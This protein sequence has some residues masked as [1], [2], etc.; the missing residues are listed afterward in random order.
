MHRLL[1]NK[2]GGQYVR[3]TSYD[4]ATKLPVADAIQIAENNSN[5]VV[6]CVAQSCGV[7][8][9]FVNKVKGE[10][11]EHGRRVLTAKERKRYLKENRIDSGETGV[12]SRSL[13]SFDAFVLYS[14]YKQEPSRRSLRSYKEWLFYFTGVDVSRSTISRYLRNAYPHKAGLVKPNMVPY[15]KF[16]LDN[17]EKAYDYINTILTLDPERIVFADEKLLKGQ[18][19]FNRLVRKDPMTGETPCINPDPDFRNTHSITG[20]CTVAIDKSPVVFRIHE[21]N[22][23]AEQFALD[24]ED[25]IAIACGHIRPGTILFWIMLHII[26]EGKMQC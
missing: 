23:N 22:N 10:L 11:D 24:V 8:D 5:L 12:G 7:S 17:I 25:A 6:H 9:K 20:F 3:G 15:D 21:G 14:L 19:L 18:E 2:N 16:R 1:T 13:D 4:L 26:L